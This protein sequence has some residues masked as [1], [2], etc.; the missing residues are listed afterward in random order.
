M[1]ARAVAMLNNAGIRLIVRLRE[2]VDNVIV[3]YLAGNLKE[4][5]I[6]NA[7]ANHDCGGH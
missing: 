7:C 2:K 1:G 3:K 5:T 4:I 6:D